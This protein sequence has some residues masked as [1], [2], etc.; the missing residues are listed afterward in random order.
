MLH[1]G[2]EVDI[3]TASTL[4]ERILDELAHG[5]EPVIV[6][7]SEVTFVSSSGIGALLASRDAAEPGRLRLVTYDTSIIR[8][9]LDLVG[10]STRFSIYA[11][12]EEALGGD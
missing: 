10:V 1:V 5:S 8:R 11:T 4:R 6:D 7:L 9:A 2:G 12:V 3:L